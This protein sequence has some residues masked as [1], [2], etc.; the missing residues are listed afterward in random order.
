MRFIDQL[1]DAQQ[2][3]DSWLC[4]GLDPN[5]ELIPPGV[6]LDEFCKSIIDATVD[7]VCAYKF[8]LAFF[9]SYG[10]SGFE[11]LGELIADVPDAIPV[12]LDAKFGDISY[13]AQQHARIAFDVLK[14]G[15]VTVTPYVGVEGILPFLDYRDAMA[16]VLIRSTNRYGNDFQTWPSSDSP[17]FRYVTAE[18]NTL[19]QQYPGQIGLSAAAT[20]PR[21]LARIRNWTPNLPF[22]IPGIG[23]QEGDLR[24]AV[25]HGATRTGIGPIIS[26]SRAITYASQDADYAKAASAAAEKWVADIRRER[27]AL[28]V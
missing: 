3:N 10:P 5:P 27:A 17:L 16:I 15:A 23:A 19:A 20:L 22:L 2:R 7:Y 11:T 28:A 24:T 18:I 1:R 6:S 8:N 14:A 9:L 21:D 12:I 26:I 13:T 25:Q 4:V